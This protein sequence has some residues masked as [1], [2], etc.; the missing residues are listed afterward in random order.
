MKDGEWY[1]LVAMCA[2]MVILTFF[3]RNTY[4]AIGTFLVV[5]YLKHVSKDVKIPEVFRKLRKKPEVALPDESSC[6]K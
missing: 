4:V 5:M 2:V 1:F 6:K 3:T